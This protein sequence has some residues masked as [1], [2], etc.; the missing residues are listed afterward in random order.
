RRRARL[1]LLELELPDVLCARGVRR[2]TKPGREPSDVA[3]IVTLRLFGE[4]ALGHIVDQALAQ[5][6]DRAN[7][8]KLIHRSTPQVKEPKGSACG[9]PRS[10]RCGDRWAALP[11]G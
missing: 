5:R 2:A 11:R 9:S 1:V 7:L 10:I 3:K 6:A 8:D 4:P